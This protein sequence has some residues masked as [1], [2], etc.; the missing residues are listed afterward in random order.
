M[1]KLS[2]NCVNANQMTDDCSFLFYAFSVRLNFAKRVTTFGFDSSGYLLRFGGVIRIHQTKN[3][4][5]LL[6]TKVKLDIDR[7]ASF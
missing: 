6:N 7:Y 4:S 1:H 3:M 5:K 2:L